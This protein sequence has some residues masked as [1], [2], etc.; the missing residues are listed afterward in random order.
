[1]FAV[2]MPGP[3]ELIIFGVIILVLFGSRLPG[4]MRS[5]GSSVSEFKKGVRD[6]EDDTDTKKS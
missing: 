1:M 5:M 3:L 4:I 6:S 2:F